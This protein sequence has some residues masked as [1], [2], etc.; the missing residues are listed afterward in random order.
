MFHG[1]AEAIPTF[2]ALRASTETL[3]GVPPV[4][5]PLS[6]DTFLSPRPQTQPRGRMTFSEAG[7]HGHFATNVTRTNHLR[8]IRHEFLFLFLMTQNGHFNFC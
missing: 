3:Q 5:A 2:T 1:D 7:E 8:H 6:W 4:S